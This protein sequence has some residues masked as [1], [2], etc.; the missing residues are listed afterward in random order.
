MQNITDIQL[1]KTNP[2]FTS[3]VMLVENNIPSNLNPFRDEIFS[4]KSIFYIVSQSKFGTSSTSLFCGA[5]SLST[6][7]LSLAGQVKFTLL[8]S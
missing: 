4:S 2:E 1:L 6:N 7:I 8:D 3:G 5:K